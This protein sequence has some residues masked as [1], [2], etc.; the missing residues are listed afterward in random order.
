M[1][2][3][4][5][6]AAESSCFHWPLEFPEVFLD[7]G[8]RSAPDGGFDAVIGNPPWEMLRADHGPGAAATV[9]F[10]REAGVYRAQ[11]RGHAN[12][13]QLFVERALSLLRPGGRLGLLVPGGLLTDHGAA[14]LRGQLLHYHGLESLLVFD[15]RKAIF[16]IHRGLRFAAV[17]AVARRQA[18]HIAC[19]FGLETTDGLEQVAIGAVKDFPITLTPALIERLSGDQLAIP[20]VPGERDL[21]LIEAISAAHPPLADSRGWNA[22]F[23][24]ELNAS[25]DKACWER[26]LPGE[27]QG[28]SDCR[29]AD[30]RALPVIEG[31]H[32]APF[33]VQLDGVTKYAAAP[34]VRA[35]LG[36]TA[37]FDRPRLAYRE[38]A[39][40]TN[41]LTLIAA[42]LPP[43]TISVHTVFCLR[44]PLTL[45][46]QD[47]LCALFNS[48]VANYLV[49]RWVTT[50]VTASIVA[51]LP[52]PRPL[53]S[54]R[55]FS[56]LAA[57]SARLRAGDRT[58]ELVARVQARAAAAFG[59]TIA[60]YLHILDSFPLIPA[61]E[62]G[63]ALHAF[64]SGMPQ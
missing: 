61:N 36:R 2:R 40:A 64:A 8:G 9:R 35:R 39:A 44:T 59:I 63:A 1:E 25:D 56:L 49:R 34:A 12:Q 13:Y 15:N 32:L 37:A 20:D 18:S 47:V 57:D 21:R 50:H 10:S 51:R 38:V 31:K 24:R 53:P 4:R 58:A 22:H 11:S 14:E 26:H 54:T 23:G 45:E 52:I 48:F 46:E 16:P 55:Q 5:R 28:S 41:R 33:A 60:D 43:R 29:P 7:A 62:R 6:L 30:S 17:T 19:R 3:V 42:I 27:A